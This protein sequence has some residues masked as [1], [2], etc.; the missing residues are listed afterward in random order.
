MPVGNAVAKCHEH[1]REE[2]RNSLLQIGHLISAKEEIIMHPTI[3]SAGAVAAKGIALTKVARN[4]LSTKQIA[5]TTEVRPVRPPAP[6]PE[7]LSTKV[8]VLDV[9]KIAPMEVAVASANRALSILELNPEPVS[10]I[11]SSSSEKIPARFPVPIK[12]PMVS[13]VSDMLKAKIVI[14]TSGRRERSVNKDGSPADV[15]ITPKVDGSAASASVKLT[16]SVVVVTPKGDSD[17]RSHNDGNQDTA[18]HFLQ[19]QN[20]SQKQSDQKYPQT[21]CIDVS[22]CRHTG[23]KGNQ[24][25]VQKSQIRDKHADTAADRILKRCRDRLMMILRIFVTVMKILIK[26]QINTMDSACC[27]VNSRAKHTV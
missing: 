22:H 20:D 10:S 5:V 6:I 2:S 24:S 19:C 1:S 8:V 26:P 4:A 12:V 17:D 18:L 14:S 7:A 15:K 16:V 11:F 21:R 3:I 27:Q 13:K 25:G 23:I 9:P